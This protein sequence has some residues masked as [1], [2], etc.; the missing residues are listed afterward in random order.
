MKKKTG[1]WLPL[2]LG[3]IDLALLCWI[4]T[5]W[6][7]QRNSPAPQVTVPTETAAQQQISLQRDPE[8]TAPT[9]EAAEPP[10]TEA[11]EPPTTE[12]PA[13]EPPTTEP[14]TTEPP[15]TEPPTTEA[16][17]TE[18]TEPPYPSWSVISTDAYPSLEDISGFDWTG[19][20]LTKTSEA[21]SITDTRVM[22]GGWKAYMVSDPQN[23]RDSLAEH[24]L[25]VYIDG[26]KYDLTITLDWY[27]TYI[28]SLG[29]SFEDSSPDSV[30]QGECHGGTIE[31]IGS[32][33]LVLTGFYYENGKEYATGKYTWPDGV[34]AVIGLVR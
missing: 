4:G 29:E 30:F 6:L 28:A 8:R 25:N 33:K 27:R 16:P 21:V 23:V 19:T 18:P 3:A 24:F 2:V 20:W 10:T 17:T 32:G 9:T 13:T 7:S 1:I 14:P 34:E 26:T 5:A 11:T 12:P 15:T 22:R 31:A